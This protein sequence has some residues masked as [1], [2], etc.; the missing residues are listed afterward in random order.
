MNCYNDWADQFMQRAIDSVS[1]RLHEPLTMSEENAWR[2]T[3][4]Y[5]FDN[6]S[7]TP[8]YYWYN[9]VSGREIQLTEEEFRNQQQPNL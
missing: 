7:Y 2:K 8:T 1:G 4:G 3:R 5:H 6:G 9:M